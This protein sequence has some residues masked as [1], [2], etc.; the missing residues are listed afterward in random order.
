M[1][2]TANLV[3]Q[4]DRTQAILNGIVGSRDLGALDAIEEG[5]YGIGSA[6]EE[7]IYAAGRGGIEFAEGIESAVVDVAEALGDAVEAG[8]EAVGD[9]GKATADTA[10][11]TG[12][13]AWAGVGAAFLALV[14]Y[15]LYK[16]T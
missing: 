1:T 11:A 9:I 15:G 5:F 14:G 8:A 10:V 3:D 4:Y 7:G 12:S 16:W 6:L 2:K 13:L